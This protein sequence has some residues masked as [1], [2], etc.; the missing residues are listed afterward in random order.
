M[1]GDIRQEGLVPD[2]NVFSERAVSAPARLAEP[3]G[4]T[5]LTLDRRPQTADDVWALYFSF[6]DAQRELAGGGEPEERERPHRAMAH[7]GAWVEGDAV[8]VGDGEED[9]GRTYA[10]VIVPA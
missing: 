1:A 8:E 10:L 6:H 9:E 7:S 3:T 4:R 5:G 2:A